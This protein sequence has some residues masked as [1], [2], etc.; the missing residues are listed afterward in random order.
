[1]EL[2]AAR[3]QWKAQAKCTT[4]STRLQQLQQQLP[5]TTATMTTTIRPTTHTRRLWLQLTLNTMQEKSTA[6]GE[7]QLPQAV[8]HQLQWP[9]LFPTT[10]AT[11]RNEP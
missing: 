6:S 10:T 9:K 5:I 8:T 1:M 3:G 4:C 2:P 11:D 7:M